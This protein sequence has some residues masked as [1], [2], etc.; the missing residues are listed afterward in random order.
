M[1]HYGVYLGSVVKG[2]TSFFWDEIKGETLNI[3]FI[4]SGNWNE[5]NLN[6]LTRIWFDN[7]NVQLGSFSIFLS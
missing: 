6:S 3:R 5:Y 7:K 4:E 1:L 2:E